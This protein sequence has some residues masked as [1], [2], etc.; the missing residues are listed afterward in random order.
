MA[1]P[2]ATA[3]APAFAEPAPAAVPAKANHLAVLPGA[4]HH[5]VTPPPYPE[6]ITSQSRTYNPQTMYHVALTLNFN[7]D[8]DSIRVTLTRWASEISKTKMA[9]ACRERSPKATTQNS[10]I[11]MTT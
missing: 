5:V 4:L 7:P 8:P 10:T 9:L 2:A 3:V 1:L 11:S 6:S